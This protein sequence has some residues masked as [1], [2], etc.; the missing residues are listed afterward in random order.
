V[1]WDKVCVWGHRKWEAGGGEV[2]IPEVTALVLRLLKEEQVGSVLFDPYQWKAESQRLVEAGYG[3]FL[4]EV[5]QSSEMVAIG[6]NLHGLIQRGDLLMY[7]D[8]DLRN[9]FLWC[10]AKHTERGY[11]IVKQQ[12]SKPIDLVVALAM[13]CW[14]ATESE[15]EGVAPSYDRDHHVVGVGELV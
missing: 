6:N 9:H 2:F 4:R 13:A 12:Q 1:E 7:D 3:R 8:G 15:E 14:G 10:A 11:R 5:N